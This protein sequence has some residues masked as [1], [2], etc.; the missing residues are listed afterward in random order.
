[1]WSAQ[2]TRVV[3]D[4]IRPVVAFPARPVAPDRPDVSHG[5]R[6]TPPA[7]DDGRSSHGGHANVLWTSGWDSTLRAADLLLDERR[8]GQLWY[9]RTLER[10]SA[11]RERPSTEVWSG[12]RHGSVTQPG[13][14]KTASSRAA[15]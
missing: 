3:R 13:G 5:A 12:V 6:W 15:R 7:T 14:A 11:K 10:R 8:P 1:M 9:V 4:R 2:E